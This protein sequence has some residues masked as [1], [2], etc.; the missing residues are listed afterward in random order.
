MKRKS[1][2]RTTILAIVFA[3]VTLTAT[4]S[5]AADL[6][7]NDT[8]HW[9]FIGC[10]NDHP[11]SWTFMGGAMAP[12]RRARI[13]FAVRAG[14]TLFTP[15]EYAT[16][17]KTKIK[18]Y[19]SEGYL[20]SPISEWDA[21]HFHVKIQHLV[22]RILNDG[23][24]AIYSRII[25]KNNAI[26]S[27]TARILI[28]AGVESEV[29]LSGPPTLGGAD[30]M[31]YDI[32]LAPGG[33]ITK[34]FVALSAGI[35][36]S[37]Q[38][39]ASGTFD[40]NYSA[41]AALYKNRIQGLTHPVALPDSN[42][43]NM[44]KNAQITTWESMVKTG[45][46]SAPQ[47]ELR[48]SGGTPGGPFHGYDIT[49][50][51]DVPNMADELA[52][53]GDFALVKN[54]IASNYYQANTGATSLQN[55]YLDAV[56]K[57][58]LP[59]AEYLQVSNDSGFF[60]TAVCQE[61][62]GAAHRVHDNRYVNVADSAHNGIM[63]KS[64]TLDNGSDFLVTDDFAALH[65]LCAYYNICH[66][67][68]DTAEAHWAQAELADL[69]NAF[70]R[71]LSVG[72]TR[73]KVDWYMANFDDNG[74]FYHY[75]YDGNWIA[76]TFMT[77]AF[78][79]EAELRGLDVGGTWKAAFDA[80]IKQAFALRDAKMFTWGKIPD[81]SWGAWWK[82]E[83]GAVYNAGQ[84]LS[85]LASETYRLEPVKNLTWLLA[86]QSAPL[87]WGE[88]FDQGDWS[89]PAA[90][91]E[92]WGLGFVK[93]TILMVCASVRADGTVI[94]GRGVPDSWTA[95]GA[96]IAWAHVH[97]NGNRAIDF[98]ITGGT[99]SVTLTITGDTPLNNIVFNLPRFKN[100]IASVSSGVI[101]DSLGTV[102]APATTKT[103][104]VYFKSVSVRIP[105][106]ISPANTGILARQRGKGIEVSFSIQR[107]QQLRITLIATN[108]QRVYQKIIERK[109]DGHHLVLLDCRLPAG[110]Y[111]CRLSGET[112]SNA[113][114]TKIIIK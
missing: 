60:T 7:K 44:F 99:A 25:V 88:S 74:Y 10:E 14:G 32:R 90:D 36:T 109:T 39:A 22:R 78:P 19:L 43:V 92:T 72:M 24:S 110:V 91:Y 73:R 82:H 34:D 87:Q 104:T 103:L 40:A 17:R 93:Q 30:S 106:A 4:M 6:Y 98:T 96:T 66:H 81:G 85:C 46:A 49:Y 68:N 58:I 63:E 2:N 69:N 28:N 65:G 12:G 55:D 27:G 70:N 11:K 67:L 15:D 113:A 51:H 97:V 18:W 83:Y 71:A 16:D 37:T 21:G 102:T 94:I 108:G 86:N 112:V 114:V 54:I 38:L 26:D 8:L 1:N 75:G 42:L 95:P 41:F 45:G 89:R 5:L 84:G 9:L 80:S 29:P 52:R 13:Q 57:Y 53:E 101:N 56:P 33:T 48:S 79:W 47:Y 64:N 62:K 77:A 3:A 50:N 31:C 105:T 107:P 61:L 20:P 23:A 59:F 76:S 35:A 100:N 111:L